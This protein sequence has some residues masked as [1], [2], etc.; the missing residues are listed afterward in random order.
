[1][2]WHH[3]QAISYAG[4]S[5]AR[6]AYRELRKRVRTV[7]IGVATDLPPIKVASH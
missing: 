3:I 6:T 4:N 5:I 7:E 2:N 1:M